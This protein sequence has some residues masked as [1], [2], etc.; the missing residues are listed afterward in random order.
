MPQNL[1]WVEYQHENTE[2]MPAKYGFQKD[3]YDA[4]SERFF[5]CKPLVN[6]HSIEI[7]DL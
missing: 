3:G 2:L 6:A 5:C 7:N 1:C 4:G